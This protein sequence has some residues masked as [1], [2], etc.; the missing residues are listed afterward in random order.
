MTLTDAEKFQKRMY[1]TGDMVSL[2]DGD[3]YF[4]GRADTQI[5]HMGYRI[6]LEEIQNVVISMPAISQA[7]IFY[8]KAHA[9]YG[10]IIGFAA[11]SGDI[12]AVDVIEFVRQNLPDYMIPARMFLMPELPKN[13]NGK[14]DRQALKASIAERLSTSD[15]GSV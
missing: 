14:V 10:K 13:A 11:A 6:E 9:A 1:C 7:A 15:T 2:R 4:N 8:H 3:L 5:K 12:A